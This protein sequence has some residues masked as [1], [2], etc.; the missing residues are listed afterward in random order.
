M[1]SNL[2]IPKDVFPIIFSF[3]NKE[4]LCTFVT[5][6]SYWRKFIFEKKLLILEAKPE[7]LSLEYMQ[8]LPKTLHCF[9]FNSFGQKVP[10]DD[11]FIKY[12]PSSLQYLE[13]PYSLITDNSI[14]S[15][16]STLTNLSLSDCGK[17]SDSFTQFLPSTLQYL[18]L[19]YTNITGVGFEHLPKSL[20]HLQLDG[21]SKLTSSCLKFLPQSLKHLSLAN[22]KFGDSSLQYLPQSLTHLS[23]FGWDSLSNE[24]IKYLPSSLK[25]LDLR[26]TN[27][28]DD[29]ISL[30][31]RTLQLLILPSNITDKGLKQLSTQLQYLDITQCDVTSEGILSLSDNLKIIQ[32]GDNT[33]KIIE[34]HRTEFIQKLGSV[35]IEWNKLCV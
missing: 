9:I 8:Q 3:M 4:T 2:F 12:L 32:V 10:F 29:C 1:D 19:A 6:S 11:S 21:C 18:N 30:L 28:N 15:L 22:L 25:E 20:I 14:K 13:I 33:K 34:E 17:L 24:S 23:L 27:L 5:L 7:T 26:S 35:D 31:P 16:P